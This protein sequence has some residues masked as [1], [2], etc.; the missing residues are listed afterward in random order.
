MT[1]IVGLPGRFLPGLGIA[2]EL[3]VAFLIRKAGFVKLSVDVDLWGLGLDCL[4]GGLLRQ[5]HAG[6]I[7]GG[8]GQQPP[9]ELTWNVVVVHGRLFHAEVR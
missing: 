1:E 6:E 9:T 7:G 4:L 8:V 3:A 5:R 2:P